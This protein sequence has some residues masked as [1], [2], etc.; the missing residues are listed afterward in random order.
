MMPMLFVLSILITCL[1][2]AQGSI[3]EEAIDKTLPLL[4]EE[5]NLIYN[6]YE[7]FKPIGE[8]FFLMQN[9]LS[10]HDFGELTLRVLPVSSHGCRAS[11]L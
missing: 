4:L 8:A 9:N 6:R 11:S 2:I 5:L 3:T 7:M 10:P 1:S